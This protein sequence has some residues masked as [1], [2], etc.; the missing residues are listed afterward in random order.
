MQTSA[1]IK[2]LCDSCEWSD[3]RVAVVHALGRINSSTLIP[4]LLD[5]D[6]LVHREVVRAMAV[7]SFD[8]KVFSGEL[9]LCLRDT[10]AKVRQGALCAL[11]GLD[12]ALASHLAEVAECLTDS[13]SG[14]QAAAAMVIGRSGVR[15]GPHIK[16]LVAFVRAGHRHVGGWQRNSEAVKSLC[17]LGA[18]GMS[19]AEVLVEYID[20]S[21]VCRS[22]L[23][24]SVVLEQMGPK[25]YRRGFWIHTVVKLAEPAK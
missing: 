16:A 3:V 24:F 4:H 2:I 21:E 23:V 11:G 13:D 22:V 6:C 12:A 18:S 1:L 7:P 17:K 14:V 9:V 8:A 19:V 25:F 5:A 20:Y 10:D 15:E